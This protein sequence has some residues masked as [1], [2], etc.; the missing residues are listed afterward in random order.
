MELV[1]VG[2]SH[3]TAPVS[4]REKVAF[5]H[6]EAE[7]SLREA[8]SRGAIAERM[9]L[10][11]CNRTELYLLAAD[12]ALGW[13]HFMDLVRSRRGVGCAPRRRSRSGRCR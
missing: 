4:L 2:L 10:S 11:T 7:A 9:L 8:N 13:D 12:P 3:K 6:A 5:S 1:V